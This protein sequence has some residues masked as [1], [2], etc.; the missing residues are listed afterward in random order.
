[1]DGGFLL[2]LLFSL[3]AEIACGEQKIELW[4]EWELWKMEH[5]KSYESQKEELE[6]HL[7]WLSNRE[8][9][10]A[11]NKNAES[12]GFALSVNQFAD[13]Q[14][15]EFAEQYLSQRTSEPSSH[16][17]LTD[18]LLVSLGWSKDDN[19]E[20][21]DWRQEGIVTPVKDQ[22]QCGAGSYAF[23]AVGAIESTTA[24]ATGQLR[25]LSAQ[26]IIDCSTS[27]GN[28][29]CQSGSVSGALKYTVS[30]GGIDTEEAY[31]YVARR[32][33]CSF[34]SES[35]GASIS[36]VI[37]LRNGSESDLRMAVAYKLNHS[38]LVVGYGTYN[39]VDYW[40]VKNSWGTNWGMKGYIYMSRNRYNQCGIATAALYPVI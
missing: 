22:G 34:K 31:P 2:V 7:V 6:R 5:G 10:N 37:S 21:V 38:M 23:S 30:T 9:I 15:G 12:F 25:N 32:A 14:D 1:M 40:I 29:G 11:H 28:R 20:Y 16:Q 27:F 36:G 3:T 4:R 13:R 39:S 35:I 24:I 19:P 26:N 8:Y 17:V 33:Y 18:E